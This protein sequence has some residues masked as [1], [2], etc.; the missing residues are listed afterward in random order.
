[1][2]FKINYTLALIA[3]ILIIIVVSI[4]NRI[5]TSMYYLKGFHLIDTDYQVTP[6]TQTI[7][8]VTFTLSYIPK[9][10]PYYNSLVAAE[11]NAFLVTIRNGGAD[12]IDF[13]P[14]NFFLERGSKKIDRAMNVDEVQEGLSNGFMGS[15]KPIRIARKLVGMTYIPSA[16]VFPGYER[17]GILVF[18]RFINSPEHFTVRFAHMSRKTGDFPDVLF[19][20]EKVKGQPPVPV[21]Q[22]SGAR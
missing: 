3:L 12:Y 1:M 10:S 13:E 11:F 6:G 17:R 21:P 16:R 22:A 8:G 7:D 20:F 4:G 2:K 18:P 9:N 5:A 15:A 14:M 19:K